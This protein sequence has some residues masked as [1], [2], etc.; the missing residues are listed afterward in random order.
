MAEPLREE[1]RTY[2]AHVAQWTEHEG[3]F[4]L[5]HGSDVI[6]FYESYEEALTAGYERFGVAAFFVRE[7]RQQPPVQFVSR[8][9][10]PAPIDHGA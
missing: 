2:E 6:G 1:T 8:L 9:V 7:V 10:A 5:I 4:V 3:Q